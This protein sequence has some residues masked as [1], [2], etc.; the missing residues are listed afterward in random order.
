ML[1]TSLLIAVFITTF[2]LTS[3]SFS[4][5][6]AK[7]RIQLPY[8]EQID[9]DKKSVRELETFYD[10]IEDALNRKD[11]D[12]LMSYYSDD[13]SHNYVSKDQLRSLWADIFDRF[14]HLN[15]THIFNAIHVWNKE[16]A[17]TCTGV[18]MG[19]PKGGDNHEIVDNWTASNHYLT[20]K[21]GSWQI[22]GGASRWHTAWH[23]DQKDAPTE[24][25]TYRIEFHPFF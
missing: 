6:D 9:A 10:G 19:L 23:A 22:M 2:I 12:K 17:V 8:S 11:L 15:S 13:Y 25:T 21:S 16:A 1:R 14:D 4:T 18:L 7:S 5:T 3:G 24:R 20:K